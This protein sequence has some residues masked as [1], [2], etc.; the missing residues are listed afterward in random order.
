M[1]A[2]KHHLHFQKL[3]RKHFLGFEGAGQETTARHPNSE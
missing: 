2:S 3:H 1:E